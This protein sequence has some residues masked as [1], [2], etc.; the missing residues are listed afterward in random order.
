MKFGISQQLYSES[1]GEGVAVAHT[2]EFD[3]ASA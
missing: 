2:A 1:F 3:I